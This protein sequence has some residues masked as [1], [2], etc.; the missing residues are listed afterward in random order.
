MCVHYNFG[1]EFSN[2]EQIMATFGRL[3]SF[4]SSSEQWDQY[5]ES[6][7][8]FF[9]AN[10]ILLDT[11]QVKK[12]WAILLSVCGEQGVQTNVKFI[13]SRETER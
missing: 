3:Q 7:E 12:M 5:I 9:E 6:L 13:S 11:A 8:H 1:N 4:D 2:Q 10:D